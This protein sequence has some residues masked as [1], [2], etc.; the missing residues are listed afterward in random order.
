M[1]K[2]KQKKCKECG[3]EADTLYSEGYCYNCYAVIWDSGFETS[4][5]WG[6]SVAHHDAMAEINDDCSDDIEGMKE[7]IG[8][9]LSNFES[10]EWR[11]KQC[12]HVRI[13]IKE[14]EISNREDIMAKLIQPCPDCG[15][16]GFL[17]HD[18]VH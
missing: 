12:G 8:Y 13:S 9:V 4:S 18:L 5:Q 1:H 6:E 7:N 15:V 17:E 14:Q 2:A 10:G 16:V 3:K 11:C